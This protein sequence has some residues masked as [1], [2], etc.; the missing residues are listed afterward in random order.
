MT[1]QRTSE[2]SEAYIALGANLGDREDT[3]RQAVE[4]LNAHPELKVARCSSLYETDPVGNEDQPLFL[5]MVIAVQ[6]SLQ[7]EA[8][9]A[10]LMK[11]EQELGRVRTIHW[12]PRTID[13]DML[14]YRDI[15]FRWE[16]STLTLPHPWMHERLFVLVPLLDIAAE[17]HLSEFVRQA[18]GKL[19]GKEGIRTWKTCNWHSVSEH[20]AN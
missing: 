18:M 4:R 19:D 10:F 5:N 20:S 9:L 12:G 7:P 11:T 13:L 16:T 1:Q 6:T 14:L 17:E 3:L 15:H 8:L 2:Y